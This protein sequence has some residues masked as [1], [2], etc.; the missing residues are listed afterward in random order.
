MTTGMYLPKRRAEIYQY[1]GRRMQCS[2][3][4]PRSMWLAKISD[5][6]F[7]CLHN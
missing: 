2:Q 4:L 6:C 3:D 5:V 1:A 7:I